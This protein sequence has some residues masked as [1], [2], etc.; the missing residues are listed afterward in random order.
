MP[1]SGCPALHGVNPIF[2]KK[3]LSE[4]EEID[5]SDYGSDTEFW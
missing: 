3:K 2:F 4:W 5:F 1:C